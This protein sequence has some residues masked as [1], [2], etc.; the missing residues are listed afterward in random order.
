MDISRR[1]FLKSTTLVVGGG[2]VSALAFDLKPARA[3]TRGLKISGAREFK[4]ACSYARS[5]AARAPTCTARR[6]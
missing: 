6:G 4:T 5:A 2:L 1:D 3:Q